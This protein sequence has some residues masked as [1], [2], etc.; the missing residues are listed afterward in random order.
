MQKN[1]HPRIVGALWLVG[2]GLAALAA[3]L[4]T[5]QVV[6]ERLR[7][8]E[9][10]GASLGNWFLSLTVHANYGATF[11]AAVPLPIIIALSSLFLAWGAWALFRLPDWYKQRIPLCFAGLLVGGAI[12]NLYDRL[13]LGYVR[14]WIML[15]RAS[16]LNLADLFIIVGCLGLFKGI[17]FMRT[18]SAS[19]EPSIG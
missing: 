8:T 1:P 3:D 13:T 6:F 9:P 7:L 16:I 4:L 10:P 2:V 11:N 15:F 19:K 14:D 12:G 5:K 18:K 17:A